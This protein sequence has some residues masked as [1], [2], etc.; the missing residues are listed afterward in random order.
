MVR[1]LKLEEPEQTLDD[2]CVQHSVSCNKYNINI[3]VNPL[4]F[5]V[6]CHRYH[7]PFYLI[8]ANEWSS[9]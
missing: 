1:R 4:L 6:V 7:S 5:I 9:G 8:G 3:H 2:H